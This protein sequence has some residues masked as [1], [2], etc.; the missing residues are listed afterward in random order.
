MSLRYWLDW[1]SAC[2]FSAPLAAALAVVVALT[3]AEA[4][5]ARLSA[6]TLACS[7]ISACVMAETT[8][9][10]TLA[11][12]ASAP[13]L[14]ASA[15]AV[16]ETV[17]FAVRLTAPP[18][19]TE[20]SPATRTRASLVVVTMA[21]AASAFALKAVGMPASA[22]DVAVAVARRSTL[23]ALMMAPESASTEA[24]TSVTATVRGVVV[25]RISPVAAADAVSAPEAVTLA[26]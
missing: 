1:L 11:P 16:E 22:L 13:P 25:M 6:A 21:A 9:T 8:F 7:S 24:S 12:E 26:F 14:V 18:E 20:A 4:E 17:F 23:P 5:S 10:A 2:A 15:L 3:S 19:V